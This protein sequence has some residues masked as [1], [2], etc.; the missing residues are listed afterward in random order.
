MWI[1]IL[2]CKVTKNFVWKKKKKTRN[3][4]FA[5]FKRFVNSFRL[6]RDDFSNRYVLLFWES[7]LRSLFCVV[8]S[9]AWKVLWTETIPNWK[10]RTGGWKL[11]RIAMVGELSEPSTSICLCTISNTC[12]CR[13][14]WTFFPRNRRTLGCRLRSL[15]TRGRLQFISTTLLMFLRHTVCERRFFLT[16]CTQQMDKIVNNAQYFISGNN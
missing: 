14:P 1:L 2:K 10:N 13:R 15:E 3:H 12:R 6:G 7:R 5:R 9:F 16:N 11:R 4:C 8:T